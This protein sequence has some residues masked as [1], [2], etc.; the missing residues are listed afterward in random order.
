MSEPRRDRAAARQVSRPIPREAVTEGVLVGAD[1]IRPPFLRRW[2][3][4]WGNGSHRRNPLRSVSPFTSLSRLRRPREGG[5]AAVEG[6]SVRFLT[7][8]VTAACRRDSSLMEGAKLPPSA[9]CGARGRGTAQRGRESMSSAVPAVYSGRLI[10]APTV[11]RVRAA[12]GVGPYKTKYV[13]LS[14]RVQISPAAA[15]AEGAER[16][17]QGLVLPAHPG[18]ARLIARVRLAALFPAAAPAA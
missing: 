16:L 10:A 18:A 1:I 13:K 4:R 5:R 7:P 14:H 17:A 3:L 9:A 11:S 15:R 8:S 12:E 6:V 2:A